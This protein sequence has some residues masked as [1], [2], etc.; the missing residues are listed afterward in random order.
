MRNIVQARN[1]V[2]VPVNQLYGYSLLAGDLALPGVL[3][4][5]A[6]EGD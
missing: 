5:V 6:E 1:G 3:A 4:V 2:E